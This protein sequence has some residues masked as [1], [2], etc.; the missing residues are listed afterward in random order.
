MKSWDDLPL[1]PQNASL[2]KRA[3]YAYERYEFVGKVADVLEEANMRS[4]G[5]VLDSCPYREL[6]KPPAN[7]SDMST[8]ELGETL[9][10]WGVILDY[11]ERVL[12]WHEYFEQQAEAFVKVTASKFK[13]EH[14]SPDRKTRDPDLVDRLTVDPKYVQHHSEL[15]AAQAVTAAW[16]LEVSLTKRVISRISRHIALRVGSTQIGNRIESANT[17]RSYGTQ[18]RRPVARPVVADEGGDDDVD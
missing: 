3:E 7:L 18:R 2:E 16:K 5:D 4:F 10:Q 13:L 11:Q 17:A 12:S 1:P 9:D 15:I 14:H 8:R 6:P